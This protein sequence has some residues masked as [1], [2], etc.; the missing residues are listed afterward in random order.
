MFGSVAVVVLSAMLSAPLLAAALDDAAAVPQLGKAGRADYRGFLVADGHR[1]FA[2]STGGAWGWASDQVSPETAETE[3]LRTCA[4][5]AGRRCITYALD[6][7]VVFEPDDWAALWSPYPTAAEAAAAATGTRPGDRFPDLS[8]TTPG[9]RSMTM[10]GLAD[11]VAFVHF[12]GSWCPPCI[13]EFPHLQRLYRTV[14]GDPGI[15]FVLLQG[16]EEIAVSRRWVKRRRFDMPLSDSG[17]VGPTD[18][19]LHLADGGRLDDRRLAPVFPTTY[20]LDRRG[21]VVFS[22]SGPVVD[23]LG[24]VPLIRHLIAAE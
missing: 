10:G 18:R 1:A 16:R 2:I 23:W 4:R 7:R 19:R 14:A 3:A 24:Y 17:V 9:G 22:H 5:F 6:D 8:F 11:K 20:I 15:A 13:V 12:W 21:I